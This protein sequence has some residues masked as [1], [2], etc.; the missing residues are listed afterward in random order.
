MQHTHTHT[1]HVCVPLPYSLVT[2]TW[3][4]W[5]M[6]SSTCPHPI[7][8]STAT[9]SISP[10]TTCKRCSTTCSVYRRYAASFGRRERA[11]RVLPYRLQRTLR[12]RG[13]GEEKGRGGERGRE[14]EGPC[15]ATLV[16]HIPTNE[17]SRIVAVTQR[18]IIKPNKRL[19]A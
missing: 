6:S 18:S 8:S 2:F 12:N 14:R 19:D 4:T 13:G 17:L 10:W 7:F 5:S 1:T 9:T 11:L 3:P 16:Q 15:C